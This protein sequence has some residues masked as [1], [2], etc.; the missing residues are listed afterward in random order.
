MPI[1][2]YLQVIGQGSW[3]D[4]LEQC[5][6]QEL[7]IEQA[8][9]SVRHALFNRR[10]YSSKLN[11]LTEILKELNLISAEA[12]NVRISLYI[13]SHITEVTFEKNSQ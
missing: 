5:I 2:I 11:Q 8:P 13:Y 3:I 9:D 1:K 4:G 6:Q 7:S 10:V 12:N